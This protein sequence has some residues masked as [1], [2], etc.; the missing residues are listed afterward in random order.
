MKKTINILISI[1]FAVLLLAVFAFF[2]TPKVASASQQLG[3]TMITEPCGN[4]LYPDYIILWEG[5]CVSGNGTC[6]GM[7]C[8]YL[9][10]V[11]VIT[12]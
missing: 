5:Y 4:S 9:A 1:N 8:G 6:I 12:G 7:S 10:P 3:K 11:V 2:G